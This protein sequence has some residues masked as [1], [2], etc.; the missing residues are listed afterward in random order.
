MVW[1]LQ[2]VVTGLRTDV[3]RLLE[4]VVVGQEADVVWLSEIVVTEI[5]PICFGC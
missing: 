1:L 4:M 2:M 3:V 5:R